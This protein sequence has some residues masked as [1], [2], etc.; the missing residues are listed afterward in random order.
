VPAGF[1]KD[2]S[3][4]V[5]KLQ[6]WDDIYRGPKAAV[7]DGSKVYGV[8]DG[9]NSLAHF[10]NKKLLAMPASLRLPERGTSSPKRPPKR[11]KLQRCTASL[12]GGQY[13]GSHV[14]TV[15]LEQRRQLDRSRLEKRP[16]RAA[17]LD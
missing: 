12:L 8:P 11:A 6:F 15:P 9:C 17:T 1:L 14:G 4:E 13:G 2:I 3:G 7:T 5:T 10:Y 16:S